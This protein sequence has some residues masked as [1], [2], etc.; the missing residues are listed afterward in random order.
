M[1]MLH[2]IHTIDSHVDCFFLNFNR[3]FGDAMATSFN[4][5]SLQEQVDYAE[6]LHKVRVWLELAFLPLHGLANKGLSCFSTMF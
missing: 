3:H 5:L 2:I 6:L 4:K 1:R